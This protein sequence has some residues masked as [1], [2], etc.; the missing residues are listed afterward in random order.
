MIDS[1][2]LFALPLAVLAV[3]AG[4]AGLA[5]QFSEA[6]E[7][8]A[9]ALQGVTVIRAD[10][11]QLAGVNLV[12]RNGRI[13]AMGPDVAVPGDAKLL[14]GDS[15]Y[16]Y[17]G[18][19]DAVGG[20]DYEFPPFEVDRSQIASWNPPRQAQSFMPHRRVA[21]HLTATGAAVADERR[22]GIAAAAV[23][24]DGRLMPGRG[25]LLVL[26]RDAETPEDLVARPVLGPVMSF[27]GASGVYPATLFA[28][29]AFYRQMFENARH[30]AARA[31]AYG[32]N[33]AAVPPPA[34]DPDLEVL[35]EV[36]E[37]GTPVF[38]AADRSRDIQRALKLA[39][40]YGFR[41]IIVGGEEAWQVADELKA[42][43]VPVLV[44]LD[45]P[46][47]ERWKPEKK[48]EEPEAAPPGDGESDSQD[49]PKEEE[50]LDAGARREKQR[51]EDIYANAGRLA[52]AGV[53]FALTSGGGS[54]DL[55]EGA[56]K[57]I[58]YGLS[59]AEALRGL[60]AAPAAMLGIEPMVRIDAGM[61]ANLIVADGPLFA[62]ETEIRYVFVEG[63][64]EK[65]KEKKAAGEAPAVVVTGTW[66]VTIETP[67]ESFA[68]TMTVK[69]E[70]SE[71]S[72]TMVTPFG[73]ATVKDGV[74][75][76]NDVN[77]TVVV[78]AGDAGMTV[79]LE[80]KVEGDEASGTGEA[81]DGSFTWTAKRTSGPE[82]E[83]SR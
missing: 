39:G 35:R 63:A 55:R 60:T 67:E 82:E 79:E 9:Y 68:V 21:D 31:R 70:G 13:E 45:F 72:G 52:G 20:A 43:N 23:H 2:H 83:P 42:A 7:P 66:E 4:P 10:G 81:P 78:G 1:R 27:Q 28:V 74:V 62:E 75:S 19:V 57:A 61:P 15:L 30:H 26:R 65:G 73:E 32:S 11:S 37:G 53:T 77:F 22:Q 51:I 76:G 56:R 46:E 5:A 29:I 41:P 18:F 47:P 16:V 36:M 12:I 40:E 58:E 64:L 71:F 38:F 50:E 14:E 48:K 80:G 25:A 59:E 44:S 54:A 34:W 3:F 17:P 33:P 6:P 24:P 69:Q 8:A 49:E